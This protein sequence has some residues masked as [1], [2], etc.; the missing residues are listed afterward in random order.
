[1]IEDILSVFLAMVGIIC[2]IILTYYASK[3]YARR[4]GTSR[5][6]DIRIVDRLRW[7]R[8]PS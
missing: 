5:R 6:Q 2:V 7:L 4:M 8:A 1:M 3:W